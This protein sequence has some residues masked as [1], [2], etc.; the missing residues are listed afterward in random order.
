MTWCGTTSGDG[1]ICRC[2]VCS[3]GERAGGPGS[4]VCAGSAV[5]INQHVFSHLLTQLKNMR[6]LIAITSTTVALLTGSFANAQNL[7]TTAQSG[8][9]AEGYT[10]YSPVSLWGG[11]KLRR[12]APDDNLN[13]TWGIGYQGNADNA[14]HITN[15]N[16]GI[17]MSF[18]SNGRVGIGTTAPGT[19]KLAVEGKLGARE[20]VVT[21]APW[22]DYVFASNYKLRPLSE[23]AR[24]IQ[25]NKHLPE[26]PTAAEVAQNGNSLAET[27]AILLRKI[28][29]LT[30]YLIELKKENEVLKQEVNALKK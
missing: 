28:E 11:F 26:V 25:E 24:F 27:D 29:E 30:L 17:M 16:A 15:G 12:T 7:S 6:R 19:Y 23:V 1:R 18:L 14:L 8:Y 22:A 2:Q 13:N 20:V 9:W 4:S 10:V 5:M 3:A 21:T